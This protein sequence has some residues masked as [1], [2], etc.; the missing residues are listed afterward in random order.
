[1]DIEAKLRDTQLA[2][3]AAYKEFRFNEVAQRLYDFFWSDYCDW[4][5]EAAKADILGVESLREGDRVTER[6][7]AKHVALF[8][9]YRVLT[10]FLRLLHP[11]MPHLT[12]ELSERLSFP[13]HAA[14][15]GGE[16]VVERRRRPGRWRRG[17]SRKSQFLLYQ[18]L[19]DPLGLS[20]TAEEVATAQQDTIELYTT[21]SLARNLRAEYN[22]PLS[23]PARFILRLREEIVSDLEKDAWNFASG[24]RALTRMINAEDLALQ[25]GLPAAARHALGAD[26]DGRVVHAAGGVGGRGGR[27]RAD[28][29]GDPQ[30]GRRPARRHPQARQRA[31]RRQRA[32][33]G[34]R[35]A[36]PAAGGFARRSSTKLR[37]MLGALG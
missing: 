11:F 2:V 5:V 13:P 28:R 31:I 7:I 8:T 18:R 33:G 36:S 9:M 6:G 3:E 14:G 27:A 26:A 4:F 17:P 25:P 23:K 24:M 30:D 12:E 10:E 37:E 1:M 15:K 19:G 29:E 22:V 16:A 32:G 20:G 21:V 35:G 34:G